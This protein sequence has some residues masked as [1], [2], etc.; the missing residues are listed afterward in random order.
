MAQA[1]GSDPLIVVVLGA[2]GSG[3]TALSLELARRFGGEI[4]S[5]DSV[6]VYRGLDV[7]TAKPSAAER[8]EVPHHLLDMVDPVE[9]MTAGDWARAARGTAVA[10]AGRKRLPVITGGTGLYLRALTEGLAPL[11][12]RCPALRARLTQK[13]SAR[14]PGYLHRMLRRLDPGGGGSDWGAGRAEAGAGAGGEAAGRLS[15]F[16][17]WAGAL[18]GFP[19]AADWACS[20]AGCFVRAARRTGGWKRCLRRG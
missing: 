20:G 3:K 7:G 11:P 15:N 8:A 13:E 14:S 16:G 9:A 18:G 4:L 5:C 17:G 1:S 12:P 10:V 6:A 19:S 2:T